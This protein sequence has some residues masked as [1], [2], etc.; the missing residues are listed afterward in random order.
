MEIHLTKSYLKKLSS[1]AVKFHNDE[2]NSSDLVQLRL[3]ISAFQE[4]M[5]N[6][7]VSPDMA[8]QFSEI[9]KLSQ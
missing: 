4:Y 7:S 3:L 5:K 9:R 6:N 2:A 1:L 8:F